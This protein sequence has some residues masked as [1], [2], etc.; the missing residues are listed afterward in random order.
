MAPVPLA[1]FMQETTKFVITVY[2]TIKFYS[3]LQ[4]LRVMILMAITIRTTAIIV[5][6]VLVG[7]LSIP[8]LAV[9]FALTHI[10]SIVT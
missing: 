9:M 5:A 8:V 7:V 10:V 6:G 3:I 1:I 4:I 2:P